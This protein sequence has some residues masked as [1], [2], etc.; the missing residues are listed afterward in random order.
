MPTWLAFAVTRLLEEHFS[1]LVDY[2]FTAAMEE[3]LDRIASGQED[4]ARWLSRFYFGTDG[5]L[6]PLVDDLGD[7]DARD[8]NTVEVGDGIVLRV[9]RYGPYLEAPGEDGGEPRRASVPDDVAPDELTVDKARE[10]L[11]TN[12]D[13]DRE[14]GVDPDTG[15]TVVARNGRFGPYV[16]EIV[17]ETGQGRGQAAH[18]EPVQEHAAADRHARRRAA[19]ALA[20]PAGRRR[21]GDRRGDHRAERPLR[22]LPQEGYG[23][24]VADQRGPDLRHHAR[25]GAGHLR[26][27]QGSAAGAAATAAAA[28]A[29]HGSGLR[30]AGRR[31]GRPV[32]PVR[33]RRHDQRDAAQGRRG[34]GHHLG[35][36]G[37]AARGEAHP[38][39]ARGKRTAAKKAAG[40]E[41]GGPDRSKKAA[42][43]EGHGE[44]GGRQE[45]PGERRRGG[46]HARRRS[47]RCRARLPAAA[48]A[49][50][51]AGQGAAAGVTSARYACSVDAREP[52]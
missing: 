34:R 11:E 9:G 46:A 36:G 28:G 10:L 1:R 4:R 14:L 43:P 26:P 5:G 12:A 30:R 25:R 29:G 23:L 8:I 17:E 3:D 45:G 37:G 49:G 51:R 31:Q 15:R 19:A 21:P 42:A 40:E 47:G 18:G 27:A 35:A 32:R 41:G 48:A 7:I 50:Y 38:D 6:K 13:G 24:A 52:P 44:E 33:D 22:S 20:A 2:D 39:R 16:T